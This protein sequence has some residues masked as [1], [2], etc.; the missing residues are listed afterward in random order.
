MAW[1]DFLQKPVKGW[2]LKII[3]KRVETALDYGTMENTWRLFTRIKCPW[4]SRLLGKV[5]SPVLPSL[6]SAYCVQSTTAGG[7]LCKKQWLICRFWCH[8]TR[9]QIPAPSPGLWLWISY[10]TVLGLRFCICKM[11]LTII[12]TIIKLFIMDIEF[13]IVYKG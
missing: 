4:P 11:E 10:L 3:R 13:I 9:V 6:H 1:S 8:T 7:A 2:I 12:P 5:R